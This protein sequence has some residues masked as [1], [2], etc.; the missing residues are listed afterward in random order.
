MFVLLGAWHDVAFYTWIYNTKYYGPETSW[1]DRV[2]SP[3]PFL[4]QFATLYPLV[5]ALGIVGALIVVV[6]VAQLQ[7]SS[8]V[9]ATR[10]WECYLL[11]WCGTSLAAAMASGRSFDHYFIQCFP[12]FAWMAAWVPGWIAAQWKTSPLSAATRALGVIALLGLAVTVLWTPLAARRVAQPPLDPAL[13]LSA[14]IES[15][16]APDD[17]I[18]VWGYNP[19]IYLYAKRSPATRFLYCT[20]HT[21]L[22]PWTNLDPAK[23]TTYAIVPGAMDALLA[24]LTR[25]QPA[26]IVD[27]GVGPHRRFS[28]YPLQKFER[29]RDYV[30]AHYVE[31]DPTRYQA[32]GFRVFMRSD[33]SRAGPLPEPT[34]VPPGTRGIPGLHG[35][36]GAGAGRNFYTVDASLEQRDLRGLALYLDGNPVG[37]VHFPP[38]KSM[39]IQVPVSFAE[40]GPQH[41]QLESVSLLTSGRTLLSGPLDVTMVKLNRSAALRKAFELSVISGGVRANGVRAFLNPRADFD[42]GERVFSV[43]APSLLSYTLP[44]NARVLR[45]RFGI[46]PG[47]YAP[48]NKAPTDGAEFIVRVTDATGT[49]H[50][51][52]QR[53]LDPAREPA[54]RPPQPFRIE[55]GKFPAPLHLEL[56]IN[57]GPDGVPS[58]DWTF[59]SDVVV[60]TA[61]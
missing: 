60:E 7:P 22:I 29:L 33:A 28:K 39:L 13:R 11:L 51:L 15:H 57:A 48:E 31:V 59:W 10:G 8:R 14:F 17:K 49:V 47:A 54:D 38:S 3:G 45:G 35:P 37:A 52:H 6:R 56:E 34:V 61:P 18:F 12:P 1:A 53:R 32:Q 4:V 24:D 25:S 27:C 50:V 16:S 44:A 9:S 5:F 2:L 58:S 21:G 23:D 19:D 55:L 43:H 46:V 26:F 20:F 42:T 41:H 36:T 40:T 30:D